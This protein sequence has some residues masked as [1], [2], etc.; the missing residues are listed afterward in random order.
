MEQDQLKILIERYVKGETSSDENDLIEE[1]LVHKRGVSGSHS[2]S[3]DAFQESL[4]EK[5]YQSLT[6]K[7][8][9]KAHNV[10]P[11]K[12][13][14]V[15]KPISIAASI[16]II[17]CLFLQKAGVIDIFKPQ[18]KYITYHSMKQV[19]IHLADGSNVILSPGAEL[20]YPEKFTSGKR[21]VYLKGKGY[22]DVIHHDKKAFLVHTGKI[23]TNVLGTA[24]NINAD[25]KQ[26]LVTVTVTRGKVSVSSTDGL[27]E[28][29][30]PNQQVS[31]NTDS[32]S[33]FKKTVSS[34]SV[35]AWTRSKLDFDDLTF[36]AAAKQLEEHFNVQIQFENKSL[37][38]CKFTGTVDQNAELKDILGVLCSF[39]HSKYRQ[40]TSGKYLISGKGC[41]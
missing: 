5:L 20:T 41:N 11:V 7:I 29:L 40:L 23:V 34:N 22:F 27:I 25:L 38:S 39:N 31:V 4:T 21:E 33:H 17:S 18:P 13:L 30:T 8:W 1:W 26:H 2:E 16:L 15:F 3:E 12:K 36:A 32:K 19:S 28:V 10:H 35:I 14:N 9:P 6:D 37:E 24:F